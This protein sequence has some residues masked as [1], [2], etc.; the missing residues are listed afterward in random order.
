VAPGYGETGGALIDEVDFLMFTGS[1]ATGK[2]VMERAAKTLT[3]IA[4]ELGGKDP[5]LVL[6]DADLER[7][8][9]AAVHYSMQNAGQTCISTERVYVEAPVYDQFVSLVTAKLGELRQGA[10][11]GPGSVDLGAVIHPP[12]SDIVESH[13]RD[14]VDK[15]ARVVA[16]GKR[17]DDNGHFY[18]PTLLLDVD[19]TMTAMREE[20]FGPTL[21]VMK[22][23]DADEGVRLAND[24]PYGL[25]ASVWTKDVAKGERLAR[26]IEAGAV[27]VNDAQINYVALELPMG[28]WKSSG[29][30]TRHGADGIRKYT[31]KQALVVTRFAPKRDLHMLPYSAKRTK[32]IERMLRLVYGRGKRA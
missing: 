16:G 30:G 26:R 14:A 13:V 1:T 27:I 18:E 23:A 21:P 10:P 22:V 29:L 25:A 17:S 9:N 12:Q 11:R 31:K 7:A 20:T 32:L 6:A 19:H 3:P 4:L 2:K 15:G 8:A 5:M 24:S 28:G